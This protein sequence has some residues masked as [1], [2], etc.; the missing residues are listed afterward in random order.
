[1]PA[2]L[3]V[4]NSLTVKTISMDLAKDIATECI[5]T[6]RTKGFEVNDSI[7]QNNSLDKS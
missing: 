6:F 5:K 3:Y 1:M 7:L 2:I 4:D